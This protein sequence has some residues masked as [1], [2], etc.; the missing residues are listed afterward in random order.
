MTPRNGSIGS[1]SRLSLSLSNKKGGTGTGDRCCSFA[2]RPQALMPHIVVNAAGRI[3]F[4]YHHDSICDPRKWQK[5]GN[6]QQTGVELFVAKAPLHS[7]TQHPCEAQPFI[8]PRNNINVAGLAHQS[9]L[10]SGRKRVG[11]C[12]NGTLKR[13]QDVEPRR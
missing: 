1:C 13:R 2:V 9:T 4:Y 10:H 12:R 7:P 11:C 5:L 3:N 6:P 8:A